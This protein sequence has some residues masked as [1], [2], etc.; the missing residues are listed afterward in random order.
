MKS[1]NFG[2]L[3]GVDQIRGIAALWIAAYHYYIFASH[4]FVLNRTYSSSTPPSEYWLWSFN[5]LHSILAFGHTA[6]SLF[7]VLSGFIFTYGAGNQ[8]IQ[9]LGFIKNR[10]L[11]VYPLWVIL[12]LC[13]IATTT[14][15]V[16]FLT[17]A[18]ALLPVGL[19]SNPLP[20]TP[21]TAMHWSLVIEFQ[22]YLLFPLLLTAAR[23]MGVFRFIVVTIGGLA[24]LRIL[25]V[26]FGADSLKLAYYGIVGR[27]DQFLLGMLLAHL[28][29]LGLPSKKQ[30]KVALPIVLVAVIVL[31]M[32]ATKYG[33]A[34]SQGWGQAFRMTL[35][36]AIWALVIAC[37]LRVA[38]NLPR[39]TSVILEKVGEM[40]F[41][42]YMLHIA[43]IWLFV[44]H[45]PWIR[46]GAGV[47]VDLLTNFFILV[48]PSVL[49]V[50]SVSF[51]AFEKPFLNL[52]VRYLQP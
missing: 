42:I 44:R 3:G 35:E 32:Y 34:T 4:Y 8:Q 16:D 1:S 18:E 26:G 7:M 27:L 20:W 17:F 52:R 39:W 12:V 45:N 11:R 24:L 41:S 37:Y 14:S 6:V 30:A 51:H 5:P 19:R 9:Y 31:M 43:V 13:G 46:S 2:Y 15:T 21:F 38:E 10:L 22:F 29:D 28:Y 49:L 50:A 36:G 33:L 40:S 47:G 23:K 48:L 25:A